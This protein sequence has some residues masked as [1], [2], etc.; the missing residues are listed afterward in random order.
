M[1]TIKNKSSLAKMEKAGRLLS[2]MF[3]E[4]SSLISPGI[5]T[6]E[7]DTWIEKQLRSKGLVA[8][9]KGYRGYKHV[10]CISVNDAVIHGVPSSELRLKSGDLVKIDVIASWKGYCADMAR[11]FFVDGVASEDIKKFVD[12]AQRALNKGIKKARAG[13]YL[14][15]ISAAI[16]QEVEQHG[17]GIVRDF[18]GHGIGKYMH[19]D[20]EVPNFG[21]P[22]EGPV[23]R[24]GMV[25]AIEP[26]ITMGGYEVF[27][28]DDG[29][30]V[31]TRDKSLAAH[32]EDT[33]VVTGGDP[34]ILTRPS[35]RAGVM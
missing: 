34:K 2:E 16:Q 17:F 5:T 7:I 13:N 12:V 9:A 33:V 4:L 30:T 14:S 29:W 23:L 15:D 24:A 28:M 6:L 25:I 1:I 20:P 35:C 10:S 18:A 11:S 8:R 3:E 21:K 19:E 31:K 27:V 26:M 22:G 32:V